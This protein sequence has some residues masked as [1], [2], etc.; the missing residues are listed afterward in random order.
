MTDLSPEE[1]EAEL[2]AMNKIVSSEKHPEARARECVVWSAAREYSNLALEARKKMYEQL[3]EE[4]NSSRE[5]YRKEALARFTGALEYEK[6][7]A[8]SAEEREKKLRGA[9]QSA[10]GTCHHY[11]EMDDGESLARREVGL[12]DVALAENG[13]TDREIEREG[14]VNIEGWTPEHDAPPPRCKKRR[15]GDGRQCVR[16]MGHLGDCTAAWGS[17]T[18]DFEHGEN[19]DTDDRSR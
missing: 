2:A 18:A 10:R 11:S 16:S 3:V 5:R 9:L 8:E 12:I 17:T 19:G 4:L 14:Q 7:R 6:L 13:D 15:Q 1:R